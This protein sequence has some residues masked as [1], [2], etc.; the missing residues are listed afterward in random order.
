MTAET[1]WNELYEEHELAYF[2]GE[3]ATSS[4]QSYSISEMK[5]IS[6]AMEESTKKV[7][8]AMR[9]DFERLPDFAKKRLMDMLA[10][11]GSPERDFWESILLD[12]DSIPDAP[13]VTA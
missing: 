7:D 8:A 9:A 1:N 5:E 10:A 11:P 12:F 13:P 6:D 2:R 4:P 3:L